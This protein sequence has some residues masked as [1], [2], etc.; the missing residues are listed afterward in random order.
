MGGY[1]YNKD[2]VS[3]RR[4]ND[5]FKKPL[6][7]EIHDIVKQIQSRNV[8]DDGVGV[9]KKEIIEKLKNSHG[10]NAVE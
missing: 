10:A 6:H 9:N 8:M 2:E 1:S 5:L 3:D 7:R 4:N